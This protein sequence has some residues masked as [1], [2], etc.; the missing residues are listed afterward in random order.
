MKPTFDTSLAVAF[1]AF[2]VPSFPPPPPLAP[3]P[4]AAVARRWPLGKRYIQ[5]PPPPLRSGWSVEFDAEER[6]FYIDS[7]DKLTREPITLRCRQKL[8]TVTLTSETG[9][10][11]QLRT[12]AR[13]RADDSI[14]PGSTARVLQPFDLAAESALRDRI[15]LITDHCPRIPSAKPK[16]KPVL[17]PEIQAQLTDLRH[18]LNTLG[19]RTLPDALRS[20]LLHR[21]GPAATARILNHLFSA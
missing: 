13:L 15:Q 1:A 7:R 12:S 3:A 21:V 11:Y 14:V 9:H 17:P 20:D 10:T 2:G 5:P 18:T 19:T 6:T 4:V 16:G 8:L